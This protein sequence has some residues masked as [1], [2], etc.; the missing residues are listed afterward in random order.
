MAAAFVGLALAVDEQGIAQLRARDAGVAH[1]PGQV[2][3]AAIEHEA[4][5]VRVGMAHLEVP[6]GHL[7]QQRGHVVALGRAGAEGEG[8]GLGAPVAAPVDGAQVLEVVVRRDRGHR[9]GGE[10]RVV[11]L[12]APEVFGADVALRRHPGGD[13]LRVSDEYGSQ[14]SASFLT[15]K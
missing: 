15:S 10:R 14:Y 6:V 13:A 12:Q 4:A 2:A 8:G 7:G 11:P 9:A 5:G 1:R 3:A